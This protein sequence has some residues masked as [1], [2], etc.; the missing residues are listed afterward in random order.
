MVNLITFLCINEHN[1][2]FLEKTISKSPILNQKIKHKIYIELIKFCK[3]NKNDN[4]KKFIINHY[5]G[6]LKPQN[7]HEFIDFLINLSEND[8]N[9]FIENI[10][11][12]YYVVE[13]DFYSQ[14][15]NLNIELL[16]ELLNKQKLNIDDKNIY[17]KSSIEILEKIAKDIDAKE[18]KFEHLKNFSNDDKN[19]VMEKLSILAIADSNI[20]Q[21]EIDNILRYYNEMNEILVKLINYKNSLEIYH[22]KIKKGEI[23]KMSTYIETIQNVT[24][25]HLKRDDKED[26]MMINIQDL[27]DKNEDTFKKGC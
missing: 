2:E 25:N 21:N 13:K 26:N 7:L 20:N 3:E 10:D 17:K 19:V 9:E 18:I 23:S 15:I 8:A 14:G 12:K 5:K 6:I 1:I 22:S 24:Y 11:N 4:I 27:F 16:N